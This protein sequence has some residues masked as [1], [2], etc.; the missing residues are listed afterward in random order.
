VSEASDLRKRLEALNRESLRGRPK[1]DGVAD[2]LRRRLEKQRAA[3]SPQPVQPI[4]YRRDVPVSSPRPPMPRI[5]GARR[6]TLEEVIE[7]TVTPSPHGATAYVITKNVLSAGGDLS[8]LN[9]A[10]LDV[11]TRDDSALRAWLFETCELDAV[12]PESV[13]L[14]DLETTGLAST[15]VFLVGTMGWEEGKLVVRQFLARHYAEEPA[16]LSLFLEWAASKALLVSFN[17][18]SF[19][20]P[21]VRVRAAANGIPFALDLPHLDLLHV[22]RRAWPDA[23]PDHRLQ[24]LEAHV[25]GRVRSGDIPSHEIPDAYHAFVRTANAAE[26]VEILRHN[27]FDL[28]TLADLMVRLPPPL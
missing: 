5:L 1:T 21:Y 18:K 26:L 4:L 2:E 22:S 3:A 12:P 25:C 6:I 16:I 24:T 7:G 27:M 19:D 28:V 15:P 23:V 14:F 20:L 8:P 13:A 11:L 10:F 17:G 9:A